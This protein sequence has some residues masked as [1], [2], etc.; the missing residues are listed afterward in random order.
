MKSKSL[1]K[2]EKDISQ[3]DTEDAE[4]ASEA[5]HLEEKEKEGIRATKEY[6]KEQDK[7]NATGKEMLKESLKKKRHYT[8]LEY[9][10]HLA[11]ILMSCLYELDWPFGFDWR[12]LVTE[13]GIAVAFTD[14]HKMVYS[15]GF[16]ETGEVK[17]DLNAIN[18]FVLQTENTID[19]ILN[20]EKRFTGGTNN[21]GGVSFEGTR[22]EKI[23]QKPV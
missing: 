13:K 7:I 18:T 22:G 20:D 11:E 17:L 15:K 23:P 1:E 10:K 5:M 16:T 2:L 4:I 3:I 9:K 21:P 14:S 8:K 12:V 19:R 6:N